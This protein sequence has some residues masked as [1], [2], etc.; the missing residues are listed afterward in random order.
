MGWFI[1]LGILVLLAI[2]PLGI[3]VR[4]DE[5]GFAAKMI[6]GPLRLMLY[7]RKRKEKNTETPKQGKPPKSTGTPAAEP[8]PKTKKGGPLADFLPLAKL[9]LKFLNDLR[10]KIRVKRLEGKVILACDDPCDLA[11]NYGKAWAAVGSV[12][13]QLERVF[14]IKKR[15][16]EVEADFRETQTKIFARLEVTITLGR[17]VVLLAIH[18]FRMLKEYRNLTN[19][20]KGGA[21]T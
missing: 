12:M 8:K 4:Y 11:V 15:N 7:P 17:L 2:F 1:A 21:A 14:T 20:R 18:G 3:S 6:A 9:A 19:K 5:E 13:P 16:V 10:R